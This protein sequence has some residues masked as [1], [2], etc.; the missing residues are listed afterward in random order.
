MAKAGEIY[1]G[2][3]G[4]EYLLTPADR[5]LTIT[6]EEILREGRVAS[7]KLRQEIIAVKKNFSLKYEYIGGTNLA[8]IQTIY[9]LQDELSLKIYNTDTLHDDYTV[10]MR[11]ITKE[12]VLLDTIGGGL[13]AGVTVEL[14]E[15]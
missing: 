3:S 4:S 15:V 1:L 10:I 11:P 14:V 9:N 6:D 2:L 5:K 7:G 12:R 8:T 13:W